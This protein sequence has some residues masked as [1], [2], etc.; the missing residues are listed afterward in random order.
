M[1]I[2]RMKGRNDNLGHVLSSRKK[3]LSKKLDIYICNSEK[4]RELETQ[5]EALLPSSHLLD[6]S[7]EAVS[8]K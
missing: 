1:G 8:K 6:Q 2:L 5:A 3:P 7:Q 4:R